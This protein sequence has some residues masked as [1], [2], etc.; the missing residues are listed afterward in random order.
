MKLHILPKESLGEWIAQ[1]R[2]QYR[3]IGPQRHPHTGPGTGN[4]AGH[5][6]GEQVVFGELHDGQEIVLAYPSTVLSPKKLFLPQRETLF[7]YA[8]HGRQLDPQFDEQPSV[9]FGVH[10]CDLR[11]ILLLDLVLGQNGS[12]QHY[13]ARR[14]NATLVSIECLEP[15]TANAFC[16]DMGAWTVPDE[17]D[18]HLTDLG[19]VYAVQHGSQKGQAILQYLDALRPANSEDQQRFYQARQEKWP[20]FPQ[21]LDL[22]QSEL[23]G[24]LAYSYRSQAWEA[25][26][27]KC[28]GCGSCTAVCPTCTCFDV[29]DEV[30]FD[31]S[32][33]SRCRIWDSCQFNE[34]AAVA[35][36]HDFR[37]NR[38]ARLRH[39]FNHKYKYQFEKSGLAGCVGCGRCAAA[40]LVQIDPVHVINELQ[41]KRAAAGSPRQ[42]VMG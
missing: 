5:P 11:A 14:T 26:G 33:G 13:L 27:Q 22:D 24:L 25:L 32:S 3:V 15:C 23:P 30:N 37:N 31:L 17:F 9:V 18:V 4:G 42:E 34:F 21:R 10:T 20:R 29:Q 28:L 19:D 12:D 36:G 39:R 38:A 8:D 16:K 41:R 35:G 6:V 7:T 40:C 1:L 2:A